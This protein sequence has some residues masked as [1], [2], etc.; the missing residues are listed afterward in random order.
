MYFLRLSARVKYL[1]E[2][3]EGMAEVNNYFEELQAKAAEQEGEI[4]AL[5][6]CE[7]GKLTLEEIVKCSVLILKRVQGLSN[8]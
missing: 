4:I 2:D 6:F 7:L 5:K 1:K 3:D 8:P